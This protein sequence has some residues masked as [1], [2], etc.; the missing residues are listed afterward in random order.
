MKT[1]GTTFVRQLQEHFGVDHV[2][3]L[4]LD[5]HRSG[6]VRPYSRVD[7]LLALSLEQ[8]SQMRAYAGHFP[9][10]AYELLGIEAVTLTILRDPVDRTVSMLKHCKREM[11]GLR[12]LELE[13][14]YER[15]LVRAA[16][17]D[18]FQTKQFAFTRE[19]APESCLT[20][21]EI[22]HDRLRIAMS[23]L[24]SVDV[25]GTT[26]RFDAFLNEIRRRFGWRAAELGNRNVSRERW[27]VSTAFRDRIAHDNRLDIAF[28]EHAKE[29]E[30]Q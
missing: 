18:N 12:D 8:R 23:N 30:G 13:E 16:F 7:S 20:A 28:Y 22:D 21:L 27:D 24:D 26:E 5:A 10:V 1:A 11:H 17:V 15:D 4:A 29:L 19:D 25:V 14:I 3:P 2:Y 6:D 9:F